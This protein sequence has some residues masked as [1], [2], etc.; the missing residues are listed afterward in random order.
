VPSTVYTEVIQ[1]NGDNIQEV[2]DFVKGLAVTIRVSFI[3]NYKSMSLHISTYN[4]SAKVKV[5]QFIIK[6]HHCLIVANEFKPET[7]QQ[8]PPPRIDHWII[9]DDQG[10][11]NLSFKDKCALWE[12]KI[13]EDQKK[14]RGT[15]DN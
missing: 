8:E 10:Y 11:A 4:S 9:N 3:G 5:G 2:Y 13:E 15:N 1:F 6:H 7:Y 14:L 12:K